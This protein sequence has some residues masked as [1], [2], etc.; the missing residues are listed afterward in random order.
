MVYYI[1]VLKALAACLITNSHYTGIYPSDI[2]AN[3]GLIGDVIFFA[4]SGYCLCNVQKS[5]FQ[6]YRKRIYRVYLP[7]WVVTIVFLFLGF[8]S[9]SSNS[10]LY[11][12]IYPSDYHFV[13]SIILLYIPFYFIMKNVRLRKNLPLVMLGIFLFAV[14]VYIF[15]YDY[16]YYHIDKV[17]EPFI[18]FLFMESMLLG[19]W[20]KLEDEQFRNRFSIKWCFFAILF[21]VIYFASKILFQK[22][23]FLSEYQFVN[24]IT[25]FILLYSIFRVFSGFDKK[26]CTLPETTRRCVNYISK[27]TLEIYLVQYVIIDLFRDIFIFPINWIV[28][29]GLILASSTVLHYVCIFLYYSIGKISVYL[30]EITLRCDR[31]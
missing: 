18:R 17:R 12:F 16:S 26:F 11:Y 21:F 22:L 1:T 28:I 4:V 9:L 20:F 6:W 8:F 23:V 7:V 27:I 2:F 10:F 15:F 31:K 24:Q 25:I 14:I 29:T 5:F 13:G 3:G 19:S 30:N